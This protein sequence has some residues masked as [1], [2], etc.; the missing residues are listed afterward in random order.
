M[1]LRVRRCASRRHGPLHRYW[2]S[3][4]ARPHPASLGTRRMPS[5]MPVQY[6]VHQLAPDRA[7]PAP[8]WTDNSPQSRSREPKSGG[9]DA[10]YRCA[11]DRLKTTS[12]NSENKTGRVRQAPALFAHKRACRRIQ[13]GRT[14]TVFSGSW[15]PVE[16]VRLVAWAHC[17]HVRQQRQP[18]RPSQQR[19]SRRA[20]CRRAAERT[21]I[22]FVVPRRCAGMCGLGMM[23]AIGGHSVDRVR[24]RAIAVRAA[25]MLRRLYRC[26][27]PGHRDAMHA[28]CR[29]YTLP[30]QRER[31]QQG[32]QN[33]DAT[34]GKILAEHRLGALRCVK[35]RW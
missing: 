15:W 1:Q 34:H 10:K 19:C 16:G 3:R 24:V 31:D 27:T 22:G 23:V 17:R 7:L 13:T 32:Q 25:G 21:A 2:R 11:D 28:C 12:T 5:D 4:A 33:A 18:R 8:G 29:R 9:K 20:D 26:A 30:G 35:F 14:V 6:R